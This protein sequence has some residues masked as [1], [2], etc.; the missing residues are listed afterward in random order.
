[1]S[2]DESNAVARRGCVVTLEPRVRSASPSPL[3]ST[4]P[5]QRQSRSRSIRR[6][7]SLKRRHSRCRSCSDTRTRS[8][9]RSRRHASIELSRSSRSHKGHSHLRSRSHSRDRSHSWSRSRRPESVS[10]SPRPHRRRRKHHK[11]HHQH[12]THPRKSKEWSP[13]PTISA[14]SIPQEPE[15]V[16]IDSNPHEENVGGLKNTGKRLWQ[17]IKVVAK[18]QTT[19]AHCHMLYFLLLCLI[20]G[21]ILKAMEKDS[22]VQGKFPD[23]VSVGI[24]YTAALASIGASVGVTGMGTL[25]FQGLSN[26]SKGLHIVFMWLGGV[27]TLVLVP[28]ILKIIFLRNHFSHNVHKAGSKLF[29]SLAVEYEALV[30]LAAILVLFL[31]FFLGL[32]F[33]VLGLYVNFDT[34]IRDSLLA[35]NTNPTWWAFF[36]VNGAFFQAGFPFFSDG[37]MPYNTNTVIVLTL[38][39]LMAVGNT[40]LPIYLRFFVWVFWRVTH[41]PSFKFLL[42]YPRE[43]STHLF[44]AVITRVL[45][46]SWTILLIAQIIVFWVLNRDMPLLVECNNGN[47]T[48]WGRFLISLLEAINTRQTHNPI[49]IFVLTVSRATGF[50]VV[51]VS[52]T[53][54]AYQ[55]IIL[56]FMTTSAYPFIV[57]LKSS[58]V[59]YESKFWT[60]LLARD[61]I[62]EVVER[63]PTGKRSLD[64]PPLPLDLALIRQM[65][66]AAVQASHSPAKLGDST[67]AVTPPA[68][69]PRSQSPSVLLTSAP[70]A[71]PQGSPRPGNRGKDLLKCMAEDVVHVIADTNIPPPPSPTHPKS[72]SSSPALPSPR[73]TPSPSPS[74]ERSPPPTPPAAAPEVIGDDALPVSIPDTSGGLLQLH[75][76]VGSDVL[77]AFSLVFLVLVAEFYRQGTDPGFSIFGVIFELLSA[78][79]GVGISLGYCKTVETVSSTSSLTTTTTVCANGGL[80]QTF[81]GFSQVVVTLALIMG[82]MRGFPPTLDAAVQLPPTHMAQHADGSIE[83]SLGCEMDVL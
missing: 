11:H 71:S 6:S 28:V 26:A 63:T 78:Y 3:P 24:P 16:Q 76:A 18:K 22:V 75:S 31:L 40:A 42:V 82:R 52:Q 77:W 1:M 68:L 9:S 67:G 54:Q 58:S 4:S 19:F 80:A 83:S 25:D 29:R 81:R 21:A 27:P 69:I 14:I 13:E 10:H 70:I 23:T 44:P 56:F 57:T 12:D 49:L 53:H 62:T 34:K 51:D 43:C 8:R 39:V 50:P 64:S 5:D 37:L 38:F 20:G 46:I 65:N 15:T 30:F 66:A 74:P 48:G 73:S 59:R 33:L 36:H 17:A 79:D 2:E 61:V 60:N 47:C 32:G 35:R 55:F 41:R 72:P 45:G 7:R